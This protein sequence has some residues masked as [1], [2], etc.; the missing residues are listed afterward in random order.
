MKLTRMYIFSI[1]TA[2]IIFGI[3]A[4]SIGNPASSFALTGSDY[5]PGNVID[6]GIFNNSQSMSVQEI[7]NFLNAKVPSC[8]TN[9]DQMYNSTQTRRQYSE[10]KGYYAP[11][12]CLKDYRQDTQTRAAE[13]QLCSQYNGGNKSSAEIIYDV[14]QACSISPKALL[15]LLQKEQS[16]VTDT[17]PW[18]IQY[19]SATGFGCPDTAPC[20]SDYYGFFNQVYNAGRIYKKY[21][22]DADQYNYRAYRNNSILYNPNS[23]CGS[24]V[25][26]LQNQATTGL[27]IYTPY[28]P[29]QAALDNL[30]GTGDGCS[31]YGNR[32]FWR[33]FSDWFGSTHTSY[34]GLET[35]RW[36]SITSDAY[37][38]IPGTD[39]NIDALLPTGTQLRFVDK[40]LLNG[41]WYLR[42]AHDSTNGFNKGI[43]QSNATEISYESLQ[44]PRYMELSSDVYKASPRTGVKNGSQVF[45]KGTRIHFS[46]KI[47]VNGTWYLR[48]SYD[49]GKNSDLA[50]ATSDIKEIAYEPFF[51][52]RYMEIKNDTYKL[53][54]IT[55]SK[56]AQLLPK[57]TQ[58]R[59]S[60]KVLVNGIWYYRTGEDSTNNLPLAV[61]GN[62][63]QDIPFYALSPSSKRLQLKQDASKIQPSTG[64]TID[65][66]LPQGTQLHL[67]QSIT[68]NGVLYY[69]TEYDTK[70]N[71]NKA[72]RADLFEEI[73]TTPL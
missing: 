61:E 8:D 45:S 46:T 24:S 35:P 72:L 6:E 7:Q 12:T 4:L 63:A 1:K 43:L 22:R 56:D 18:S 57:G 10:S 41:Q 11:F 30:Y 37:K 9:G 33:M 50:I 65:S 15:V 59:F 38:K 16:L 31:A 3:L 66:V 19:R 62:A 26:F 67:T 34:T 70:N 32:N 21:A 23:A 42:T 20:D 13:N 69:R 40:I 29:N 73:P 60:T 71:L 36:M 39:Q 51:T 17:W 58:L 28:Q 25:V 68:V 49:T 27:Y 5:Q 14:A 55:G 52:P 53:N 2:S 44:T 54:P 64:N 48:S 47:L